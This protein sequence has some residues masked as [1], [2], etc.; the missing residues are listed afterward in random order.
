MSPPPSINPQSSSVNEGQK[1]RQPTRSLPNTPSNTGT[2]AAPSNGRSKNSA[3]HNNQKMG[4]DFNLITLNSLRKYRR[5]FQMRLSP[6]S[7][8]AELVE[9]VTAH[10]S[11]L[12]EP[13]DE[14]DVLR[15]FVANIRQINQAG[16][17]YVD[18]CLEEQST[19]SSSGSN[20]NNAGSRR[21][22][23][24]NKNNGGTARSP[25]RK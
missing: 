3:N 18:V 9:A 24:A 7:N 16:K 4:V 15:S 19:T 21:L 2:G 5:R 14:L 13:V 8:K 17:C 25:S 10:F 11:A 23:R 12:P 6:T 1:R 22:N 20:N